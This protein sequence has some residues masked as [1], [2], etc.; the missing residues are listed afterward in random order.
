MPTS[1]LNTSPSK[2]PTDPVSRDHRLPLAP[3]PSLG[4]Q[5]CSHYLPSA[6]GH[7]EPH[8]II[9]HFDLCPQGHLP[10]LYPSL[11]QG[12]DGPA[13]SQC[14]GHTGKATRPG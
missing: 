8:V 10:R 7:L 1:V 5:V 13:T 2:D 6:P 11:P 9:I 14:W 3:L 12:T 4:H